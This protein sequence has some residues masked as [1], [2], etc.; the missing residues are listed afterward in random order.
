[1]AEPAATT[2]STFAAGM[3][4]GALALFGVTFHG[5]LWA[6]L[7]AIVSLMFTPPQSRKAAI[8]AVLG[9]MLSGAVLSDTIVALL[10]FALD[11]KLRAGIHLGLAFLIGGGAKQVLSALLTMILSRIEGAG[12]SQ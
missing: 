2:I 11:E 7:G 4:A 5:L 1:M 9:G 12:K 6:L 3:S 8:A 10:S